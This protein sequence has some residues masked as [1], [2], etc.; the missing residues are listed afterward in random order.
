MLNYGYWNAK[1]YILLADNYVGLKDTFQAKATLQSI[2]DNY[3]GDDDIVAT[4]QQKLDKLQPSKP[5]P[6]GTDEMKPDSTLNK[7]PV[8]KG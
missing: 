2:I 7:K 8:N 4:A 6:Q 1:A 5:K 3:K